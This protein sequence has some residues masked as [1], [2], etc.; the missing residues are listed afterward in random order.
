MDSVCE[1][2]PESDTVWVFDTSAS[3]FVNMHHNI[4]I[5]GSDTID[6]DELMK[7]LIGD[8]RNIVLQ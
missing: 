3:R 5:Q 2:I 1:L 6:F 4:I 8:A 7:R